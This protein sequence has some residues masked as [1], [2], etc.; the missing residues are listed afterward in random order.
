MAIIRTNKEAGPIKLIVK[1]EG[2]K[3]IVIFIKMEGYQVFNHLV[4]PEKGFAVIILSNYGFI[5]MAGILNK[6]EEIV[7][8]CPPTFEMD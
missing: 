8:Q 1:S 2:L 5:N 7:Y 3:D 4:Y 6:I